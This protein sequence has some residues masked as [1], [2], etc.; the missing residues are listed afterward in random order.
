M[1][2]PLGA[3][4]SS[5]WWPEPAEWP[6]TWAAY[7]AGSPSKSTCPESRQ[8]MRLTTASSAASSCVTMSIEVPRSARRCSTSASASWLAWS[9]PAVGSSMTSSS[10]RPGEGPGDEHAA[11]LPTREGRHLLVWPGRPGRRRRSPRARSARSSRDAGFHHG[12]CGSRP[13]STI[14]VTVARTDADSEC[15]CGTY[16]MRV[17][18]VNR[19]RGRAEELDLAPLLPVRPRMPRTR[20]DLPDPFGPSSATTSPWCSSRSTPD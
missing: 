4:R 20:V 3:A 7:A 16:P 12:R 9:T 8:T 14:S 2:W 1:T 15:R 11:L 18:S 17:C 6:A 13:T 5:W 19:S 10:G